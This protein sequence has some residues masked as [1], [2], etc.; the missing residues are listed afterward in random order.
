MIKKCCQNCSHAVYDSDKQKL[1]CT[2]NWWAPEEVEENYGC[3]AFDE[4][5]DDD[6]LD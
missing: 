6:F 2:L 3:G 5:K 1:F 4:E